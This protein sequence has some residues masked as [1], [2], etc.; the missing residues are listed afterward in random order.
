MSTMVA[1]LSAPSVPDVRRVLQLAWPVMLSML[2]Y[3]LMS[4]ADAIF[5]GR[6]GTVPL[7]AIGIAVTTSWLF[8]ALP[9]GLIRGVRVAAAQATGAGREASADAYG[10]QAIWL[11]LGFGL[12][13]ALI[14][15]LG[16][17]VLLLL[18]ASPEVAAEAWAYLSIRG[19]AAPILL[20]ELG[21]TAWFEGRGD[22][23][24]PMRAN[25]IANL[26]CIGLDAVLVLGLGPIPS[27]GIRGAAW[28]GVIS[29]AF[30][31]GFLLWMA[32]DR[33]RRVSPRP[34]RP[35]LAEASRLGLPIGL[36]RA[37]DLIAWTT[38][39]GVLA[40]I[41]ERELAAHTVAIRILMVS[42]L[43]GMAIA[44]AAAVLVGQAVGARRPDQARV[45]WW[46]G[47]RAAAAVM[48][49]GGLLFVALPDLLMAPFGVTAEVAPIARNLL[50]VAAAFQLLDAL[51]TVT[52]LA[53]DGAGD[54]RFT[55][56]A[57]IAFNWG[58][59]LPVGLVLAKGLGF[60]AVGVWLALTAELVALLG[61]LLWRWRSGRWYSPRAL[62][63]AA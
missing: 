56:W 33:L 57:S 26:L 47:A 43:P 59:K 54:T 25:V 5:V 3:S 55:L 4:A 42:F 51:A 9:Y 13:V 37:Q 36:Q 11:A 63:A 28:A 22:T 19:L 7:A 1:A 30:A 40:A 15:R 38:L 23:R 52:C 16:H 61:L 45:A 39:T 8:M 44:E 53:L 17:R 48:A 29:F 32:R 6:L 21:L 41:G 20:L 58:L 18:G 34:R 27:L 2:T 49:L 35:L 14:S 62:A 60:G 10:W 46:S 24:T 12:G 31:G 50:Y